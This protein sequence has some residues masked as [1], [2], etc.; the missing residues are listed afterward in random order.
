M[1]ASTGMVA[2]DSFSYLI[3]ASIS[4]S[5][6]GSSATLIDCLE[7]I[8]LDKCDPLRESVRHQFGNWCSRCLGW[9][10]CQFG[11]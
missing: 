6:A 4:R 7:V 8:S 9:L 2:T 5:M 1:V 11:D 10:C 3:K